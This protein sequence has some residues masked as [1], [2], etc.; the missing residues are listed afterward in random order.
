[1]KHPDFL[2][3]KIQPMG[4]GKINSKTEGFEVD[5]DLETTIRMFED[6]FTKENITC[7]VTQ[8]TNLPTVAIFISDKPSYHL[9]YFEEEGMTV[10]V[11]LPQEGR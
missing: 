11:S 9:T 4:S 1:M 5:C 3:N 10:V 2:T 6:F 7:N 8:V